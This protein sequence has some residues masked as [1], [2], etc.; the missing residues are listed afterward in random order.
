MKASHLMLAASVV[1]GLV[2][3]ATTSETARTRATPEIMQTDAA[4]VARVEQ[5]AR[6]RGIAVTW[7]NAPQKHTRGD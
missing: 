6:A 7:V 3:C 1:I 2:G 4:Y 5:L